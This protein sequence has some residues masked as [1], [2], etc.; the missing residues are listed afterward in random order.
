M[1]LIF[2]F[3]SFLLLAAGLSSAQSNEVSYSAS[4]TFM[5]AQTVTT[6]LT[7]TPPIPCVTPNCNVIPLMTKSSTG[8]TFEASYARRLAVAGPM[9]LY[10]ELPVVGTP[11]HGVDDVL[12][13][14]N[15]S[16]SGSTSSSLFF[17]TPSARVKFFSSAMFSPWATVGGG[18]AR[19]TLGT[20]AA[21]TPA[22]QFG[23]GV[24]YKTGV[25]HLGV[26]VE[27]RD[28][29]SGSISNTSS[30]PTTVGTLQTTTVTSAAHHL[31]AGGGVVLRF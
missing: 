28:F 20:Q 17:L 18:W 8:F 29:W 22:L 10:L 21:N 30:Q 12:N 16:F 5:S 6:T 1:K 9:A 11:A 19:L 7:T 14:N 25:P 4:A 27:V 15:T 23:G 2:W 13:V 26:R 3:S 31:L 24:D